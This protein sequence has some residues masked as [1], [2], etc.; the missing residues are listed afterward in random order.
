MDRLW[1]SDP[2]RAYADWQDGEA[3]GADRRPFSPRS[4]IQHRAM[5]DRFHRYLIGR[6]ATVTSFG[7]DVL[8]GFWLD[9]E[10]VHYSAATRKRYLKLIDRLCRH[11]VTIGV[12]DSNPAG[13]L[14]SS[15]QWPLTDPDVYF[16][17]Q[18]MDLALQE[19]VQPAPNED[20]AKLQ[21]RAI[22]ALF[23]GTGVTANEG[24]GAR[25]RDLHLDAAPPYLH[26]PARRPKD[27]RT[28]HVEPFALEPLTAW[29]AARRKWKAESDLL[30]ALTRA[31]TPIT[32][33]SLGKIVREPCHAIGHEADNISP[34][35]LRNTY[36]RRLLIRG[37][38]ADTVSATLG[39]V[40]NRTV[41]RIAATIAVTP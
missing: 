23:L 38:A 13:E 10:A 39:L 35:T 17:S 32:D 19:F 14:A 33:M 5:F 21:K 11:L 20:P 27:A 16:L 18:E 6:G 7:S 25:G 15:H 28:V 36:C 31:G 41:A 26:V 3:V 34:R 2:A 29:A 24:R 40:S 4:I 1:L 22:V 9:G 8:D 12:R 37:I 30:F